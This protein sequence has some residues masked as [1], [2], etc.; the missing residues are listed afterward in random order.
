MTASHSSS[1]LS[2]SASANKPSR[3]PISSAPVPKPKAR[4]RPTSS[5]SPTTDKLG[6]DANFSAHGDSSEEDDAQTPAE[7]QSSASS[8]DLITS[9]ASSDVVPPTAAVKQ[10]GPSVD[11]QEY[12][13]KLAKKIRE[14]QQRMEMERQR[15]EERQ[16]QLEFEENEREQEQIRLV[17]EQALVEQERL[18]RAIDECDRENELKR[19]EEQ[20]LQQQRDEAEKRQAEEAE[21]LQRERQE[22]A[23]KEEEERIERKKRLDL[24]MKRT[25]HVS[26]NSKV[27]RRTFSL[28]PL[29]FVLLQQPPDNTTNGADAHE[30][31]DHDPPHSSSILH[32]ISD[33]RLPT[34]SSTPEHI[35]SKLDS[36]SA[37]TPKYADTLVSLCT[38]RSTF[39]VSRYKSPLIQNLLNRARDT[40][41]VDN[42]SQ[43]NMTDSQLISE[44]MLDETTNITQTTIATDPSVDSDNV[45]A[46]PSTNGHGDV[47]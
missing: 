36:S 31:T 11:E 12:Q 26:P 28:S 37:D 25:R 40:R 7:N 23:R 19:Q 39:L 5:N 30:A 41:S 47:Q 43:S 46:R 34:L 20:R 10:E 1:S 6:D 22:K 17:E 8:V 32:S 27:S 4:A 16:R 15:E 24:I 9:D 2:S 14:A 35:H 18:Q 3:R 21:R 42:L 33:N 45:P 29:S 44:S 38:T 13:R